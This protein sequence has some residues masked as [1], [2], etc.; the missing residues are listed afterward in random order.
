[1]IRLDRNRRHKVWPYVAVT[2]LGLVITVLAI[3]QTAQ[4]WSSTTP[5]PSCG[6][7]CERA[8]HDFGDMS[9]GKASIRK[10]IFVLANTG[11]RPV[12]IVKQ[13]S[14]CG[15]TVASLPTD[16]VAPGTVVEIPVTV[17][18]GN[19]PGR[20]RATVVLQT[21]DPKAPLVYLTVSGF[22]RAPALI[23]PRW[24]NFGLLK[25]GERKS[26]TVQLH[27]GTD[28]RPFRL[29]GIEN[30]SENITIS[31]VIHSADDR[32]T[33]EDDQGPGRFLVQVEAPREAGHEETWIVFRTD[34]EDRPSVRLL[35]MAKYRGA[36][37]AMPSSILFGRDASGEID[38][39]SA[40]ISVL[41]N[42]Q[43]LR[44]EAELLWHS[45]GTCPFVIESTV[46]KDEG[47]TRGWRVTLAFNKEK[48]SRSVNRAILRVFFG[49]DTL[50]I[51]VVG[52]NDACLKKGR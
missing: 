15:C 7:L 10:H 16:S 43:D 51:P 12:R 19:R 30:T 20:Q 34:I 8:D 2:T 52:L 38:A 42:Q 46:P 13:T 5:E 37:E 9:L 14:T 11:D 45:D 40:T 41:A 35:V 27:Q 48:A 17:D 32:G 22:I 24:V 29:L 4:L 21:D 6:L 33:D 1:M 28:P 36:I 50:D 18:W 49:E 39:Q 47:G 3:G 44:F 26:R 23:T 25:A 31:R